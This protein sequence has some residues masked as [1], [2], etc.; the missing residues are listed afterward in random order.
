[1]RLD[2]IIRYPFN[3]FASCVDFHAA[4]RVNNLPGDLSEGDPPVP[5]PN[6]EV[7][8]FSA[9]GTAW[10]TVWESRTLPR[11]KFVF[12]RAE[13]EKPAGVGRFFFGHMMRRC[14]LFLA[15]CLLLKG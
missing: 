1:M 12:A 11:L 9:D 8:P 4:S 6:T 7:K 14:G 3:K 13:I 10:A 2:H 5:I 15:D